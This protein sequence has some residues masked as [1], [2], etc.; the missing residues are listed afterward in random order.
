MEN[1]NLEQP[2]MDGIRPNFEQPNVVNPVPQ[3]EQTPVENQQSM[4]QD[5]VPKN[6]GK[7]SK[8]RLIILVVILIVLIIGGGA[9]LGIWTYFNQQAKNK[10]LETKPV[11]Q[12]TKTQETEKP[13]STVPA[14]FKTI[15]LNGVEVVYP[16]S[17]GTPKKDITK[18]K[19]ATG[20]DL[21]TVGTFSGEFAR[22]GSQ[23]NIWKYSITVNDSDSYAKDLS[24]NNLIPT[25]EIM[26]YLKDVYNKKEINPEN[27]Y[28]LPQSAILPPVFNSY[29]NAY[30][31]RYI[32]SADGSWRGY[33]YVAGAGNGSIPNLGFRSVMY[34]Y[35]KGKVATISGEITSVKYDAIWKGK[36]PNEQLKSE[37]ESYFKSAYV[38]DTDVKAKID[39]EYLKV[40]DLLK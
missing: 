13:V 38:K 39:N 34:N 4:F 18:E 2:N 19:L 32:E 24:S 1:E 14:G 16:E 3:Q 25:K 40:C 28:A 10:E 35:N 33:W 27:I 12:A 6:P 21:D 9:G 17:W 20:V 7:S 37:I 23:D 11:V 31:P 30:N 15:T 26:S 5:P 22:L 36:E 8:K 29:L